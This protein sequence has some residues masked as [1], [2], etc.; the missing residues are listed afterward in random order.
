MLFIPFL[1]M[2]Q[3]PDGETYDAMLSCAA[4]HA[5]EAERLARE[6]GEAEGDAQNALSKDFTQAAIASATKQANV[7]DDLARRKLDYQGKLANGDV[8]EIAKQWT[9]LELAC[10]ELHPMLVTIK[11]D[12][13]AAGGRR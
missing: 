12:P 8:H 3:S 6:K 10:T 11:P 7:F 2:L 1:L 4:F 5:I 13:P 9:A